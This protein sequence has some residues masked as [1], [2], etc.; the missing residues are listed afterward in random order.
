[1]RLPLLIAAAC[2]AG[3]AAAQSVPPSFPG[4]APAKKAQ[5]PAA[6]QPSGA[7]DVSPDQRIAEAR[8]ELGRISQQVATR[9]GVPAG[10]SPEALIEWRTIAERIVRVY[11]QARDNERLL[12]EAQQR[13]AE[14]TAKAESWTGFPTPPPHSLL[15]VDELRGAAAGARDR[16]DAAESKMKLLEQQTD[17]GRERLSRAQAAAR[18]AAERAGD[19]PNGERARAVWERDAAALP[20]RLEGAQVALYAAARRLAA[21]EAG[22]ARDELGFLDKQLR[23]AST[24]V[25]FPR[26]DLNRVLARVAA[27]REALERDAAQVRAREEV[28][29]KALAAAQAE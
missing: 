25:A 17:V 14:L 24:A 6:A 15:L 18:Q 10:V 16:L 19:A 4:L 9:A 13:R 23:V 12:D 20:A 26:A 28:R 27:E 11:T 1:M 29:R 5:A 8:A 22:E 3:I 7:P 2:C 21:E